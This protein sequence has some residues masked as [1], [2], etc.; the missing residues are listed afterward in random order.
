MTISKL[1]LTH[2]RNLKQLDLKLTKGFNL[3]FGPNGSGKSS[4]LEAIY[5]L[6]H[7][8][9]FRSR[10]AKSLITFEEQDCTVSAQVLDV[11]DNLI[12]MG[13]SKSRVGESQYHLRGERSSILQLAQVLPIQLIYPGSFQLLAGGSEL[14]RQL[15]DWGVFHVEHSF[16]ATWQRFHQVLQQRN[17]ALRQ[18]AA[19]TE[20]IRVWDY[21]F[22]HLS[23][24]IARQRS[25]FS[26]SFLPI[27]KE[28]LSDFLPQLELTFEY[29]QGWEDSLEEQ[30]ERSFIR[31][32]KMG[33]SHVGPQ[34]ADLFIRMNDLAASLILSRGQQKLL[35]CALL[36]AQGEWLQREIGKKTIYLVDDLPSELDLLNREKVLSHLHKNGFQ[37]ILTSIE[38]NSI[39]N[40]A[41]SVEMEEFCL[42]NA[43]IL[44]GCVEEDLKV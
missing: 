11:A 21:E 43:E 29:W 1:K 22:I 36:L 26:L 37:A 42:D 40:A 31:D 4:I 7:G 10:Q 38:A 41:K 33:Y 28:Y 24:E 44:I 18:G 17:A 35:V 8:R 39:K 20:A 14:R 5:L 27:V 16:G 3:V 12:S 34:R 9:S 23:Q 15:I 25:E 32:C 6:S 13:V 2:F 30:L 19:P